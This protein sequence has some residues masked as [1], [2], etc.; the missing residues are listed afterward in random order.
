MTVLLT[1]GSWAAFFLK[2][3]SNLWKVFCLKLLLIVGNR[4]DKSQKIFN[5][6]LWLIK[7]SI[8]QPFSPTNNGII[9]VSE[10]ANKIKNIFFKYDDNLLGLIIGIN[11]K[12]IAG[13]IR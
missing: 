1:L 11:A 3:F 4:H 13:F 10:H 6:I 2:Q 8:I 9:E 7:E 12:Q 5:A